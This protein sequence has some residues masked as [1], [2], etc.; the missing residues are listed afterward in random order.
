MN[1]TWAKRKKEHLRLDLL[2]SYVVDEQVNLR[3]ELYSFY[4]ASEVIE[5]R[6]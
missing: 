5:Y 1:V 4:V 6:Q 2:S 3:L